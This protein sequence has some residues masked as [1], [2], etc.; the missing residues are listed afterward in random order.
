MGGTCIHLLHG[1]PR[2]SEDL[3]FDNVDLSPDEF[4]DLAAAVRKDLQLEG[5]TV[6]LSTSFKGAFRALFRFP[7]ILFES[8]LTGHR[9]QKLLIQVDTEPQRFDYEPDDT[10]INRFDVFC[11]IHAVPVD[12]LLAQKLYCILSQPRPLGRD[13]YD[14][15]FLMGKT[16]AN[17]AYLNAKLGIQRTDDLKERLLARGAE[18]DLKQLA[19]DIE[20]FV[21]RAQD[22]DRVLLF[23]DYIASHL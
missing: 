1:S 21:I 18:L 8:G 19:T 12:I 16:R 22:T 3:D 23:P 15:V 2:F 9:Q 10:I 17:M 20:P 14:A 11:R 6:E 7:A 4:R 13:F 5:Y